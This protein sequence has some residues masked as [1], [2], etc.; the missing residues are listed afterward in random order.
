MDKSQKT[1]ELQ[2]VFFLNLQPAALKIYVSYK[3][4]VLYFYNVF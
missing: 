1:K 2:K 4:N 3:E